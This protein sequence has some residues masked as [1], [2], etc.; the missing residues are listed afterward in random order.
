MNP[1]IMNPEGVARSLLINNM[2]EG[3][4]EH[5]EPFETPIGRNPHPAH[6][7]SPAIQQHRLFP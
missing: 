7:A 4:S 1:F 5:Y 3:H 2:A 6:Q